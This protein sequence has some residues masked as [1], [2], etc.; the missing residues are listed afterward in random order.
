[1][2]AE[3]LAPAVEL[4]DETSD[5]EWAERAPHC[6]PCDLAKLVRTKETPTVA[7]REKRVEARFLRTWW[8]KDS[9]MFHFRG[10]LADLDGAFVEGVLNHLTE[11]MRPTKGQRWDTPA[12][13]GADAL[14]AVCAAYENDAPLVAR[15]TPPFVVQVP[16]EGPAEI[17]G[18]PLPE[19]MVEALRAEAKLEPIAVDSFGVPVASGRVRS[20]LSEKIK[21]AVLL[22]D[23]HC[24]CGMCDASDGLHVHH[25]LPVSW[26][27]TDDLSNLAAVCARGPE[28][29][30]AM[31]VPYGDWVLEG[32]PN[33]PD[34]L[35]FVHIS[36]A[37]EVRPPPG[38]QRGHPAQPP[39]A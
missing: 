4:A 17:V 36:Q 8:D 7:D 14:V 31:L 24:R 35:R 21:R 15:P 2:S 34:G 23:G 20:A 11:R 3:Q 9:G 39:A 10:A 6:S 26:G 33:R 16:L 29:H 22:R 30:H 32:N 28:A 25:L 18:I 1:L 12:H 13:R 27:G 37:T 5:R 19:E 38:L